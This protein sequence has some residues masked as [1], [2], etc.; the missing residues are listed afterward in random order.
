MEEKASCSHQAV[1]NERDEED[2]VM[3]LDEAGVYSP[4]G[5]VDEEEIGEGIDSL[6]GVVSGIVILEQGFFST[7]Q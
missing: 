1:S 3:F 5:E 2:L 4:V 7:A 6:G